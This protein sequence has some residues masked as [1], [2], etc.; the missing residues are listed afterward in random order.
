MNYRVEVPSNAQNL[1]QSP[2]ARHPCFRGNWRHAYGVESYGMCKP[3]S[4][5]RRWVCS[6]FFQNHMTGNVF[7]AY[8]K[9]R[10]L[11]AHAPASYRMHAWA[12]CCMLYATVCY[13]YCLCNRIV[14]T[15]YLSTVVQHADA[16]SRARIL[17]HLHCNAL[18]VLI[19]SSCEGI[20]DRNVLF[21]RHT[22]Y[23]VWKFV[24]T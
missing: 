10:Y 6:G 7:T 16:Q 9:I 18:H 15:V 21:S 1:L 11:H 24:P 5:V 22:I 23:W 2:F 14:S 12:A 19:S 20:R 3:G 8:S 13:L 4:W 17:P